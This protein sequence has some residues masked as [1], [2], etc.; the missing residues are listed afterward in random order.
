MN[1]SDTQAAYPARARPPGLPGGS[2]GTVDV[3]ASE[4]AA[5]WMVGDRLSTVLHLGDGGLAY[6]LAEQGHD[7]TVLGDDVEAIRNPDLTY[8]RSA[9][10]RLPLRSSTFDVVIT[11][12]LQESPTALAEYARV[13][14]P[15]GL[16]ST[17]TRRY[18]D[19]IPWVR[20]LRSITGDR[21]TPEPQVDTF[22]ASGLFREPETEVFSAWEELDLPHLIRF[23]E[24][25]RAP[26]V[27]ESALGAVHDLWREYA[28]G[29]AKLRLRHETRCVRAVVDKSALAVEPDP[30]DAIL[31]SLD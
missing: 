13:L 21:D 10:E 20:R 6:E 27:P 7:V 18:D 30:P 1:G 2:L 8:I 26:S 24:Q 4:R 16:L 14:V 31:L 19:S 3:I 22:S 11:P 12:F 28:S 15:G 9:G 29:A 23:A 25:T 5:K 17:M